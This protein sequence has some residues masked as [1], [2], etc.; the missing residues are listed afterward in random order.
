MSNKNIEMEPLR[1]K[2]LEQAEGTHEGLYYEPP[3]GHLRDRGGA[4]PGR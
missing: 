1:K 2:E 3:G 4:A